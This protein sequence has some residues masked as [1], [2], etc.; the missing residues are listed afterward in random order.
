MKARN[1]KGLDPGGP[2][3]DNARRIAMVRLDELYSFAGPARDPS[4]VRALH[5][6]RIAAKRLRYLLELSEPCFGD[7]A[8][9]GAKRARALQ[10]LL[11]EI[12]DCDEMLPLVR[13]HAKRLRAEDAAAVRAQA[14]ANAED[15]DPRAATVAPNRTR[16]RGLESL[17]AY[18]SAR[19]DVLY[20]R[21]L[22]EWEEMER[23]GFRE[24]LERGLRGR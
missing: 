1:V 7:V 23:D 9:R 6:M 8:K 13:G 3:A 22:R 20:A 18:L 12:H 4:E 10:T 15:L 2:L 17:H 19:R 24:R 21:F 11:G 16:H 14:S 5:D